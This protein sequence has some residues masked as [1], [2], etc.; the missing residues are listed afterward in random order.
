MNTLCVSGRLGQDAEIKSGNIEIAT[1][2]IF[3]KEFKKGDKDAGFWLNVVH[4]KPNDFLKDQLKKGVQVAISGR[5]TIENYEKKYYTKMLA[6]LIEVFNTKGGGNDVERGSVA[7]KTQD[8]NGD[9]P[10]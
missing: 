3:V 9:L 2:S 4:F 5:L 8:D 10:F 6:S 7:P 1:F